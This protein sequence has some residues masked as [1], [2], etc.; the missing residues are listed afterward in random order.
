LYIDRIFSKEGDILFEEKYEIES[1]EFGI[2]LSKND[3]SLF[4][5]AGTAITDTALTGKVHKIEQDYYMSIG[6]ILNIES[7]KIADELIQK[8]NVELSPKH[9]SGANDLAVENKATRKIFIPHMKITKVKKQPFILD[10]Q[11]VE[12]VNIEKKSKV[13]DELIYK[14]LKTIDRGD[15]AWDGKLLLLRESKIFASDRNT[16]GEFTYKINKWGSSC[17]LSPKKQ[18]P[19]FLGISN[20]EGIKYL[21]AIEKIGPAGILVTLK[22]FHAKHIEKYHM[23]KEQ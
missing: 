3:F 16:K 4:I 8:F 2:D 11:S 22:K 14:Q 1:A 5:P 13:D 19:C 15:I 12:L 9:V 17:E 20:K 23:V 10:L 18:L 7:K 6:D 21:V